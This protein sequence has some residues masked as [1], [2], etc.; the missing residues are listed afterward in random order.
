[1]YLNKAEDQYLEILQKILLHGQSVNKEDERTGTGTRKLHNWFFQHD[2]SQGFP[3][4]TSKELKWEP[5]V[6]ELIAFLEGSNNAARF[7]QL[8]CNIWNNNANK[9]PPK[10]TGRR[11]EWLDSSYREGEDHL[12]RIYGVQARDWR[13]PTGVKVDQLLNL[14]NS[15]KKNPMDRRMFVTHANP[16]EQHLMALPPCHMFYQVGVMPQTKTIDLTWYQRSCDMF[17]GVPFNIASYGL[18]LEIL[19]KAT[20][21]KAGVLSGTLF[22]VHIYNNHVEQV[23]ELVNRQPWGLP[24][25]E[26]EGIDENS[27]LIEMIDNKE[28]SPAMFKLKN[29]ICHPEI[30]APMAI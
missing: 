10:E 17:L 12:G 11:N 2:M 29:Y 1:M 20:G 23:K 3:A 25:L 16:G 4:I 14:Y 22:D 21:Y 18:I 24:K 15:L 6:G 27:N 26:I 19:A 9:H 8:G 7:R 28:L 5:V 13:S 30:K